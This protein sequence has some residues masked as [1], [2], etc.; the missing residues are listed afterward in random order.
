MKKFNGKRLLIGVY[1][2]STLYFSSK[3]Y[4]TFHGKLYVITEN[5]DN[6]EKF[7]FTSENN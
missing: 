1:A 6:T 5:Q 7:I 2:R 3:T 4:I